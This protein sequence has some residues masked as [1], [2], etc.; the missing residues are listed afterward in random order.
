MRLV[1]SQG[2]SLI[3]GFFRAGDD[4][5]FRD[6]L[7]PEPRWKIGQVRNERD[8]RTT[9]VNASPAFAELPVEMR[10]HGNQKVGRILAPELLKQ[11][12]QRMVKHADGHLQQ[13]QQI[14]TAQRPAVLQ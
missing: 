6:G 12:H 3:C 1:M 14:D 11:P 7:N 10:D 9:W 5:L 4:I 13:T 8:E 2:T